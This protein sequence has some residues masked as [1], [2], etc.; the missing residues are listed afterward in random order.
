MENQSGIENVSRPI[1][2]PGKSITKGKGKFDK[3][4]NALLPVK[5]ANGKMKLVDKKGLLKELN[6]IAAGSVKK[7]PKEKKERKV[8]DAKFSRSNVTER[9]VWIKQVVKEFNLDVEPVPVKNEEFPTEP[10]LFY[11]SPAGKPIRIVWASPRAG[12][13]WGVYEYAQ[14]E[15]IILRIHDS[16]E[17]DALTAWVAKRCK[18]IDGMPKSVPKVEKKVVG[19]KVKKTKVVK[20]KSPSTPEEYEV[21]LV[22]RMAKLDPKHNGI[23]M[24]KGIVGNE[25]WLVALCKAQKWICDTE[26]RIIGRA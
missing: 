8:E 22:E 12:C 19:K 17:I 1:S 23:N 20:T 13:L 10:V 25:D 11:T 24:P 15:K 4:G 26:N 14:D 2:K 6:K 18:E 9:D 21:S 16:K 3:S 7:S 5:Q